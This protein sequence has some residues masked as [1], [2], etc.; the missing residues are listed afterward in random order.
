MAK[1]KPKNKVASK[2]WGKFKVEGGKL[3]RGQTCPKC[4]PAIFLGVHKD[5]VTCGSCGYTTFTKK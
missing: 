1:K 2:R 4:G 5:R 3:T